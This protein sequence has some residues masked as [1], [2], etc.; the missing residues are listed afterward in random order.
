METDITHEHKHGHRDTET[1]Q[2][3]GCAKCGSFWCRDG[4]A[5][6]QQSV[7]GA[8]LQLCDFKAIVK[9]GQGQHL[10]LLPLIAQAVGETLTLC[11]DC[12]FPNIPTEP[13]CAPG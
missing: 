4:T 7:P 3:L 8:K 10:R 5:V 6:S 9:G 13:C 12:K 1:K 2:S 11:F